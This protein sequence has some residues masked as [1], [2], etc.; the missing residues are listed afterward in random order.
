MLLTTKHTKW[1]NHPPQSPI[2]HPDTKFKRNQHSQFTEKSAIAQKPLRTVA[3]AMGI[4]PETNSSSDD[5]KSAWLLQG[6][7]TSVPDTATL[8]TMNNALLNIH[9]I[10]PRR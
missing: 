7:K 9:N 4:V 6:K 5:S 10:M 2:A 8:K 3:N 1:H